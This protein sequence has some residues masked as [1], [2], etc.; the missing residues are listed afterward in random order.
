[1]M[2]AIP[3]Q[4]IPNQMTQVQLGNQ[5]CTLAIYQLAY[6]LFMDVYVGPTLII[7]GVICQNLNRIVRSRYLGFQ[8]DFTFLDTQGI[9]NPVYSGLGDRWVLVYL[10]ESELPTEEQS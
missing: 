8:G 1:M 6:G 2:L 5:S 9:A 10:E 4:P 3:L 7:A